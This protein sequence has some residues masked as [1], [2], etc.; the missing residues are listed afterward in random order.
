VPAAP[1]SNIKEDEYR[2]LDLGAGACF[3][4][5][6]RSRR[7]SR[8]RN[9]LSAI[10]SRIPCPSHIRSKLVGVLETNSSQFPVPYLVARGCILLISESYDFVKTCSAFLQTTAS[11]RDKGMRQFGWSEDAVSDCIFWSPQRG[12]QHSSARLVQVEFEPV[13]ERRHSATRDD[14][15]VVGIDPTRGACGAV[16][17]MATRAGQG[18]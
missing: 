17:A 3:A 12:G 8:R 16:A 10:R 9:P 15:N 11:R 7:S 2:P 5:A 14:K 18:R 6:S 13:E 4:S 1:T